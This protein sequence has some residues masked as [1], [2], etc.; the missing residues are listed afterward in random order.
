MT[1]LF[2]Y[3]LL[4]TADEDTRIKRVL[5]RDT[6]TVS[7]I[8]SRIMNQMSEDQKKGKSDFIIENESTIE[9]LEEK[10]LFFL[11]LFK[12]LPRKL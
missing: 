4:I 8:K 1:N 10:T 2:D 5:E 11:N 12:S 7:E 9:K 3:I 6:E